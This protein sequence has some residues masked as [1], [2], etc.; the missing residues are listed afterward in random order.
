M[1][2]NYYYKHASCL[3]VINYA[4]DPKW[5]SCIPY[6]ELEKRRVETEQY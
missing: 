6:L 5:A 4:R 1:Y 2:Y 3:I